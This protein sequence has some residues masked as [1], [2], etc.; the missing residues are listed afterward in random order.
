M[1]NVFKIAFVFFSSGIFSQ[2]IAQEQLNSFVTKEFKMVYP[3]PWKT[4]TTRLMGTE[5]FVFAPRENEDD[6]FSEN[7][8]VLIQNLEGQSIDLEKYKQI[9]EKQIAEVATDGKIF[10]SSIL[11]NIHGDYYKIIYSMTQGKFNLKIT[12]YCFIKNDKAYLATFTTEIANYE[13][14]KAI[15]GLIL[16]SFVVLK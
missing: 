4:D 3:S 14:Y 2:L 11:K 16:D 13:K 6:Q 10:E 1:K 5:V 9:T 7:V 15:G 12:S 8:N